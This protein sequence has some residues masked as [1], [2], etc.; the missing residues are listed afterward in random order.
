MNGKR[1]TAALAAVVSAVLAGGAAAQT[2]P[3]DT[4]RPLAPL[5]GDI[6][7]FYGD[8]SPFYGDISPFYGD[9]SPFWGDI[10]PFYGDIAPFWGDITPFY[11]DISPFY[12]DISPFWGDIAPFWGDISPFWKETDAAWATGDLAKAA[13]NLNELVA[14][15]ETFWGETIRKRTGK[16]FTE[17]F[18]AELFARYGLD[19]N[20]PE[21][22]DGLDA[23][24]RQ[25]FFLDWYDGLMNFS[26]MDHVDW[27]MGAINWT[28]A[29]TQ[30][31]GD[32]KDAV[33]GLL[34][35][36]VAGDADVQSNIVRYSGVSDFSNGHGAAVASLMVSAHDGRGVMGIAPNA[37]VVA[38]NPFDHTGT[39]SWNDVRTGILEIA[40]HGAGVINMS[41]GVK[42]WTLH[43]D[44][45]GV[46]GDP[47]VHAATS[48][49]IFVLAAGNDGIRQS[50][51]VAWDWTRNPAMIVVG[52]V[53]PDNVIS[54]F[55]N[56]PGESCLLRPGPTE[57]AE[58]DKLKYRF[59]VA[60]G[61]LLLVSD[62]RGGVE[63]RSGTSFA[64]PLVSG[65]IALLHDRWPWLASRPQTTVQILFGSAKDLG[66]AG[67]DPVYGH[68][69]LDIEAAQ[70]WLDPQGLYFHVYAD[71]KIQRVGGGGGDG[72]ED[73]DYAA[74][75]VLR[76]GVEN[77]TWEAAG[78]YVHL[79]EQIGSTHRDFAIPLSS[80]LVDQKLQTAGGEEAFHWFLQERLMDAIMTSGDG[81]GFAARELAG[82]WSFAADFK[83]GFRGD[84]SRDA[85]PFHARYRLASP[86]GGLV[87]QYGVGDAGRHLISGGFGLT[88][89]HDRRRGGVN[90][91]FGFASGGVFAGVDVRLNDRVTV[92]LGAAHE[93]L[94]EVW[95]DLDAIADAREDALWGEA[96]EATA[97]NFGLSFRVTDQ[98]RVSA[99]YTRLDEAEALLG[100]QSLMPG[101]LDAGSATDG[102]T[103]G[104][105][106]RLAAGFSLAGSST[107]GRTRSNGGDSQ[108]LTATDDGV[109]TSAWQVALGKV[110]VFGARDGVRL[111]V[112]QKLHVEQGALD[113]VSVQVVDRNTG[114]IGV[115]RQRLSIEDSRRDFAAE[116][117]Y[118]TPVLKGLGELQAFVR[119]ETASIADPSRPETT[120]GAA[121]KFRF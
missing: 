12:G 13:A 5:Y 61:E 77:G 114:E 49:S 88:A 94:D 10:S 116:A 21:T 117:R 69:L 16:D 8:I 25:R 35:F 104:L 87:L 102:L 48:G 83:P 11:G 57:C 67:V 120:V 51:N 119:G 50:Q 76:T 106:T 22:L 52:S 1:N 112:A 42:G 111:S 96:Y 31:Q 33:I 79:F 15:S 39:A 95:R 107:L 121:V 98:T 101:Q 7:P 41:L 115:V 74:F 103:V 97:L 84:T 82:G 4:A 32:G 44:W 64:A 55:S 65:A 45:R 20:R 47:A 109:L 14:R 38:Y 18:A 75:S 73:G 80:K 89:D 72:A 56:R 40:N 27:W 60:P 93:G 23:A 34:D 26:G 62:D 58:R 70:A 108:G 24:R 53:G 2:A 9:I 86:S 90:P 37:S 43:P 110:G 46:F 118:A 100:V 54:D 6:S 3:T 85:A 99:S 113:Y 91:L 66:A 28:P 30:T 68:G 92:N 29:I 71:G 105:Q 19:P 59:L 17:G 63:R 81:D 78:A 36:V